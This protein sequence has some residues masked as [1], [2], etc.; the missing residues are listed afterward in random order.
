MIQAELRYAAW[1]DLPALDPQYL[2]LILGAA[3]MRRA[4]EKR[5]PEDRQRFLLAHLMLHQ[6]VAAFLGL[7]LAE[8]RLACPANEKPRLTSPDVAI[9]LSLTHAGNWI[10]S[11]LATA[12]AS[13]GLD[14]EEQQP[15]HHIDQ[16]V[17]LF[18]RR[19][20][21][22]LA[23]LRP[24][25]RHRAFLSYWTGKEAVAK[26]LG[27]GFALAPD[28]VFLDLAAGN[29]KPID[30]SFTNAT[31][32]PPGAWHLLQEDLPGGAVLTAACHTGN[33]APPTWHTARLDRLR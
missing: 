23:D 19:E 27:L 11:A 25:E 20:I 32:T 3:L 13:I 16:A 15:S 2:D 14:I 8:V 24:A 30:V 29:L 18:D 7:P 9:D 21:D 4:D 17:Q 31:K 28:A 5:L 33:D 26:A 6:Q 10:G 22:S 12:G 1:R